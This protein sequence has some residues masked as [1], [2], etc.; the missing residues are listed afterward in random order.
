MGGIEVKN[1]LQR[2]KRDV[3]II[4]VTSHDEMMREAFGPHSVITLNFKSTPFSLKKDTHFFSGSSICNQLLVEQDVNC[5]ITE[6]QNGM[7]LMNFPKH[8]LSLR[9]K[10]S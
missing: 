6:F 5:E 2:L 9:L 8:S 10:C 3:I 7:E 1:R 4:Y